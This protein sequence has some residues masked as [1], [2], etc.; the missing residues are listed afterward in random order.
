MLGT[1]SPLLTGPET[2][3]EF[4]ASEGETVGPSGVGTVVAPTGG[5]GGLRL[6][7]PFSKKEQHTA[8]AQTRCIPHSQN[9]KPVCYAPANGNAAAFVL[10]RAKFRVPDIACREYSLGT[11]LSL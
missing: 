2:I 8:Y 10:F 6:P 4:G 11:S 9:S 1:V 3:S 7:S 5:F